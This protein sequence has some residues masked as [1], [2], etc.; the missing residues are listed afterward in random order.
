MN[1]K[2]LIAG[3]CAAAT[4]VAAQSGTEP[5]PSE[6]IKLFAEFK[7]K[8]ARTYASA[9]EEMERFQT[10]LMN[11]EA[12]EKM[13]HIDP[14]ARYS[15]LTPFADL[16]PEQFAK[17]NGYSA[18][19][20]EKQKHAL[21]AAAPLDVSDLPTSYDAREKGL[22][23]P[24]K[25]QAQCGS[26]WAFATVANIE[27][28][29]KLVNGELISLSEQELVDC[30][31][32]DNGCNGGLPSRAYDD[33]MKGKM[34]LE[35]ESAYPY[36]AV[37]GKSCLAKQSLQKVFLSSYKSIS[38]NEDQIA[39][40]LM[41]Y[42][43]L[44]IGINAQYMQLYSGGISDPW[45]CPAQLDHG[46][47]IVGFGEEKNDAKWKFPW[48]SP[49]KKFWTIKNSWGESWGEKGYYR[50]VRGKGKCGVNQMVTSAIVAKKSQEQ[51]Y[52]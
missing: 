19:I 13:K 18:D 2:T 16:T 24:V 39:A 29:N 4:A 17:R 31:K 1:V 7:A 42:G 10:F 23:N 30:S 3:L 47:A 50:I 44:A 49:T 48:T 40:A 28:Q 33:L 27:G 26:C 43:P 32:S 6:M 25:N 51:L 9:E 22:V 36:T 20:Q 11:I 34:G 37:T 35:L 12:I 21:Q 8:F 38:T 45:W 52:I 41:Q 5:A 46:V 14:S 15:V